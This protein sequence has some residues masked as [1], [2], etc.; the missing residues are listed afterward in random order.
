M[1]YFC[2][3]TPYTYHGVVSDNKV[4]NIG[5]LTSSQSY[6]KGELSAEFLQKIEVLVKDPVNLFRGI[7]H[8]EFCPPPLYE[9]NGDALVS[10]VVRNCP[11]GN[12][13]I[14]VTSKN[15]TT[16]VAPT[17]IYHYIKQHNYLPPIEFINAVLAKDI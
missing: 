6:A 4:L 8:C 2:D 10:K 11:S 1:A 15:G 7:H 13:E 5:W 16:Y 17:L 12:G 14:R 3:L 9:K